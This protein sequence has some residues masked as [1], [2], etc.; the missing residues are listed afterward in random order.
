MIVNALCRG[1]S[2]ME[3]RM[4]PNPE[5]AKSDAS[6]LLMHGP[7]GL[8]VTLIDGGLAN[9]LATQALLRVRREALAAAGE[10]AREG[11]ANWK[12]AL[13]LIIT[14]CHIDHVAELCENLIPCPYLA[15]RAMHL[16]P[17]TALRVDGRYENRRNGDYNHRPQ[18][19]AAMARYAPDA[20]VEVLPYGQTRRIDLPGGS[21][22]LFAPV[23]DWGDAAGERYILNHY[24]QGADA[25]KI[26]LSLP[27][28]AVN[29]NSQW[30]R[31]CVGEHSMLFPGDA[32]KRLP[33]RADESMDDS[34]AFYG[35]ALR[36]EIVKYPHHGVKRD[37]AAAPLA[38]HLLLPHGLVIL[39]AGTA[40][41]E[42]GARLD[43]LGISH[44]N[45]MDGLL[46]IVLRAGAGVI[47][48]RIGE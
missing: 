16:P 48:E 20:P 9:D 46:R 36:S 27:V 17:A 45:V 2:R 7:E 5:R 37:A 32:M 43:A 39:A 18:L 4:I 44:L 24:L 14:H 3:I 34:I 1:E 41:E 11:D 8:D 38:R 10:A 47:A 13:R 19:L 28:M 15:V 25:E 33:D 42:G 31:A 30:V 23:R 35:E 6:I 22:R 26:F 29:G 40:D 21:L 12:L